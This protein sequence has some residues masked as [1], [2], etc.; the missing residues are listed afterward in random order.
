MELMV[1]SWNC[2][3]QDI[4]QLFQQELQREFGTGATKDD[5]L[6]MA[7]DRRCAAP[8]GL[9][10]TRGFFKRRKENIHTSTCPSILSGSVDYRSHIETIATW[11]NLN[12][13]NFYCS[14]SFG[15]AGFS[16]WIF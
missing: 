3:A 16:S 9:A 12:V 11:L 15:I 8:F 2:K 7:T 4:H 10:K 13:S 5:M 14:G 1:G 6:K